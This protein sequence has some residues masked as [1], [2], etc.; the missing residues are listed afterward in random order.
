MKSRLASV[1]SIRGATSLSATC[2][3][4]LQGSKTVLRESAADLGSS[5]GFSMTS[6]EVNA[7]KAS[8]GNLLLRLSIRT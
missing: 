6:R 8:L 3:A 1:A 4:V 7:F 2:F 5:C